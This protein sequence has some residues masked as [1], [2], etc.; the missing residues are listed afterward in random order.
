M[1]LGL[2]SEAGFWGVGAEVL[3]SREERG[4]EDMLVVVGVGVV[5]GWD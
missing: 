4:L 5:C 3:M 1:L 2:V